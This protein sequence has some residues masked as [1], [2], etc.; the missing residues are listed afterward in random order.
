MKIQEM[1]TMEALTMGGNRENKLGDLLSF[2]GLFIG[3][4]WLNSG[5]KSSGELFGSILVQ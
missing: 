2:V 4:M 3:D 5:F 1:M